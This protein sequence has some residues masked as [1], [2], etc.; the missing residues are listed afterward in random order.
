M[1]RGIRDEFQNAGDAGISS[2]EL[3]QAKDFWRGQFAI[4]LE[5][6]DEIASFY[7]TRELFYKDI[8]SPDEVME[9]V[10]QI[11]RDEV[12]FAA[13]EIFTKQALCLAIIGPHREEV[14]YRDLLHV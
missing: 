10:E 3:R 9:K 7:G 8:V 6:S 14:V 1:V 12:N 11:T 5:S 2:R 4:S 13:R